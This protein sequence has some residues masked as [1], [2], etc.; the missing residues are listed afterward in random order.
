MRMRTLRHLSYIGTTIFLTST[1]F[2][3]GCTGSI[4]DGVDDDGETPGGGAGGDDSGGPTLPPPDTCVPGIPATTQI[5]RMLNRQYDNTVRDLLGVTGV[6]AD[7]KLPS[8]LLVDDFD[9]P[10][11][12]PAW[13]IYQDV[14]AQIAKDVMAGPN[15][16]KFISCDPAASGCL[17]QTIKTFGRKAFR[18]PLTDE[19]VARFLKLGQTTPAGT[20][21]EVAETT[22]L[23][24][25]VSP[26]FLML[27]E[28]TTTPDPS[29]RGIKLSSH[30]A[31][32][33]LSYLLWGSAPDDILNAAADGDQLQTKE[34]IL[35]QAQRMIAVREKTGPLV[36]AFHRNWA[37]MD[38]G[39]AHWWKGDHDTETY[40]L[41][42]AAAK[43]SW[44]A[45]LNA[46][47]EE[48]AF[49][50]GSFEDLL[51]SNV[52]FVNKDN[53]AI[54]GLDPAMYGTELTKVE[55]DSNER[56]GFLTRVGFLSSY[57]GYNATS[58]ILRGA[59][60]TTYML[61]VNPGPPLPGATM[62]TVD[63]EFE[64]QRAYVE[65]LTK[66]ESCKGCHSVIN[67]PGFVMEGFDGIG[68]VQTTDP[69][70][71]AIDASVTTNT[72]DFGDGKVKEITSPLQLMQEIAQTQKAKQL[73]AQAWISY[74]YGRDPNG[75]DKCLVDQLD[76]KLSQGGYTVLDLM[77][78]L[79]QSDS[80]NVR[81]RETQ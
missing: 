62:L 41:Y 78:D 13:G 67:P 59:F 43:P 46:F 4:A 23:A 1:P 77:A 16:S 73:Y 15:K 7:R 10:M 57:S 22:L 21:E 2:F 9:G 63:G 64:T 28:L 18:R 33:R 56:P 72:I 53:A 44:Q 68:K 30:E 50:G 45:E 36:T 47:F 55:L 58:P 81:V 14:A 8:E 69:R 35:E 54:Y 42:S 5:P 27:P 38:N 75:N 71:G 49:G 31:A 12:P 80:F 61:G 39:S 26:S 3:A 24:F 79:T 70:G 51:L 20:P 37:Q 11:T 60:I 19:E 65:E 52:A 25:L 6:G 66:P 48:V 76:M 40:P 29:G 17:E 32:T 34:Q 74:A